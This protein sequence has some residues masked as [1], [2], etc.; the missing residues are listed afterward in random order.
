MAAAARAPGAFVVL[1]R[2]AAEFIG[3]PAGP[4]AAV[5]ELGGW[6]THANQA[7]PNGALANGLRQLDAGLAALR[8]GLVPATRGTAPSSSSPA[9][10]AA[11]SPSTARSAPT[12]APAASPSS[13]A[14][15]VRGGRVVADWPGLARAPLRRPRPARDDRPARGAEGRSRRSPAGGAKTLEG[16]VFPGSDA[17]R[18]LSLL[19]A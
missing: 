17:I 10:S 7:N 14:A 19:R 1:A 15:P 9:S 5:L 16:E 11:K 2:R 6:D 18:N 13:S 12:T 3:Q 4:Q 8:N